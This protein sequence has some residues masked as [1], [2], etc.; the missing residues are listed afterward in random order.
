[1]KMIQ[2]NVDIMHPQ[3]LSP[4]AVARVNSLTASAGGGAASAAAA[5]AGT[6]K[7]R[8]P[9]CDHRPGVDFFGHDLTGVRSVQHSTSIALRF[10]L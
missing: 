7:Q 10:Y 1:M 2:Q 6:Q 4:E 5:A 9:T 8:P 3:S